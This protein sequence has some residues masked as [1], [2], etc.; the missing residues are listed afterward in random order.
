MVLE[1]PLAGGGRAN[2]V[3]ILRQV[4]HHVNPALIWV[5]P[6]VFLLI[7]AW[8]RASVQAV[9]SLSVGEGGENL[10]EGWRNLA[11]QNPEGPPP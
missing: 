1:S 5:C 6:R 3:R 9:L 2:V 8:R 7:W 11:R 10:L 4:Y